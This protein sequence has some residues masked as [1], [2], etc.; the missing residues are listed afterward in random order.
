MVSPSFP[1]VK[2]GRRTADPLIYR[3]FMP[4]GMRR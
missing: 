4:S 1:D 2:P 3:D